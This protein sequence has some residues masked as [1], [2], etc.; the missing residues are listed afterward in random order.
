MKF[1]LTTRDIDINIDKIPDSCPL[2]SHGIGPRYMD[3]AFASTQPASRFAEVLFQCPRDRC[4]HL[5]LARYQDKYGYGQ[6]DLVACL[7]ANLKSA[8]H[9]DSINKVSS[10]FCEVY[11]QAY[12]AEQMQ[13]T[14][15]CGPGYRKSLEFLIKDYVSELNPNEADKIKE[16]WLAAC[17]DKYVTD[18]NVKETAKR[19]VWLGNDET[20]YVKTWE[21]KDLQDLKKLI[22]L[23]VHWIEAHKLTEE[24]L[25]SMQPK[26]SVAKP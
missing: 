24:L 15:V 10:G 13:L 26:S 12:Q 18:A 9:S 7:P 25:Q 19:A 11:D 16:M 8:I 3:V 23:T 5:F 22:A 20:H 6:F 1:A 4:Q 17:I 21:D 14:Q 2:C